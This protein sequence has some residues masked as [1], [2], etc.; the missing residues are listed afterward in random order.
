MRRKTFDTLVSTAGLVVA[1]I[2]L[3]AGGLLT[4]ANNFVTDQ[5]HDQ[6]AAQKIFFPEA[7]DEAYEDD[8]IGPYAEQYA[9]EQLVN[10]EQ[11]KVY[12]DH[13]IAVHVADMSGDRTYS[14]VSAASRANPDDEEAKALVQTVFRGETLRGLLLNAYAFWKMGQIALYAAIVSFVGAGVFL[15]LS[16]LGFVHAGRTTSD[17]KLKL[18]SRTPAPVEP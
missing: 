14:E 10:G 6:L 11:A 7:G 15:V 1:A 2:L 3:I 12:A 16:V 8:R 17:E 9:G 5:V 18:G 13:Y 4:W